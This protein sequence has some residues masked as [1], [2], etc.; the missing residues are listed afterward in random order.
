M[1]AP[2]LAQRLGHGLQRTLAAL[3]SQ[4]AL[5]HAWPA[6]RLCEACVARFAQP[7]PRCRRCALPV[8]TGVAECAACLREPPPLD[9]CLAAVAYA[10]PW[11]GCLA[12]FKFQGEP[13]WARPLAL[14]LRSAPWVEPTLEAAE[15]VLPVPLSATRLRERGYNQALLLARALAPAKTQ[16]RLL[17]RLRDTPP[18]STLDR[19][20]RL[21]SVAGAFAVEPLQAAQ[22]RGR[23]VLLVDDTMTSGATLHA[24]ARALR[25][26]GATTVTGLVVARTDAH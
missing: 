3:P 16:A 17:L 12:S 7:R 19:A 15:L 5:C 1:G 4:C 20:T 24:A 8:P 21:R 9:A 26:A 22:L 2:G 25:E 23:R 10:Y 14:L 18:Q 11:S 13:G 6:R